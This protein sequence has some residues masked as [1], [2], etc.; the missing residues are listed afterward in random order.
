M[1]KTAGI[2]VAPGEVEEF[3]V[4][5]ENVRQAAVVGAKDPN[6]GEAVVAFVVVASDSGLTEDDLRSW[7]KSRIAAFKVPVRFHLVDELPKTD[8]GKLA[9][10][11]LL[12][13]DADRAGV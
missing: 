10:R 4:L 5:H 7:C 13:L 3:L 6:V 11:R 1:I 2:N 8:T 9:R 12:E